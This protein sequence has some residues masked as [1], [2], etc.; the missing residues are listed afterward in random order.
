[1]SKDISKVLEDWAYQPD[2]IS[3]RIVPGDDG[4]DKIQMRIDLG[5]LQMELDGRPDGAR[6][7]GYPSWLD[8][9]SEK[10]RTHDST[11]ADSAPF[12][13]N[14]DDCFR[15]WHEG[16][17]YY[18]RYLCFWHLQEYDCCA[19]D[20]ERNLRLF[21]FVKAYAQRDRDRLQFDQ[22]RPYVVVMR[23]RALATPL[24]EKCEYERAL[25]V[26]EAGA[27]AVREY[28]E[29]YE[30]GDREEQCPELTSLEEWGAEVAAKAEKALADTPAGQLLSLRRRLLEAVA[31]ERFE[32]AA[33]LRDQIGRLSESER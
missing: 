15:L 28:L 9:Y 19:R 4:R 11:H 29:E 1:M 17:Q 3:A 16:L 6:P 26:I 8:Y 31:D 20:T 27:D 25:Q 30:R 24:I 21:A 33:Q 23:T 5:L 22:F 13:L 10:Q 32:E 18:H 14:G 12:Q 7:E 2:E